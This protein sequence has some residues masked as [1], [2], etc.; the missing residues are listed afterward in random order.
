METAENSNTFLGFG[1]EKVLLS[2]GHL[3]RKS[4]KEAHFVAVYCKKH[5]IP[6]N[7]TFTKHGGKIARKLKIW[8][9][10]KKFIKKAGY[11]VKKAKNQLKIAKNREKKR[12]NG[13]LSVF[14]LFVKMFKDGV[15]EG[16]VIIGIFLYVFSQ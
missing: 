10:G 16:H 12:E 11:L 2:E 6:K 9:T 15:V 5:G 13:N 8:K 3:Y 4:E 1:N 7:L 14:Y